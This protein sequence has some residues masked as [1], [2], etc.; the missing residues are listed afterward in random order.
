MIELVAD[1][2][3]ASYWI[4]IRANTRGYCRAEPLIGVLAVWGTDEK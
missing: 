1:I 2:G 4:H 3:I